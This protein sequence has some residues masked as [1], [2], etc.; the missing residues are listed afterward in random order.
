MR[1]RHADCIS[2]YE[3]SDLSESSS[4]GESECACDCCA[5]A[6]ALGDPTAIELVPSATIRVEDISGAISDDTRG[7]GIKNSR[8]Q[9]LSSDNGQQS[10]PSGSRLVVISRV[11]FLV[12][13]NPLSP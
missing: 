2:Q 8:Q 1:G 9:F 10:Q 13:R 11:Q 3:V 12:I 4:D 6:V 7:A 5:C